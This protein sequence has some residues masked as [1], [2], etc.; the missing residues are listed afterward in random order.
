MN[1]EDCVLVG[2]INRKKDFRIL[3]EQGWYR[4]PVSQMAH[5][6]HDDYIAFFFSKAFGAQNGSIRYFAERTGVEQHT[7]LE[8]L[9]DE[10]KAKN[11]SQHYYKITVGQLQA[12]VPP[13]LNVDKHR[14]SFIYTTGDRFEAATTIRELF[15][16]GDDLL[17][18]V[19]DA[20]E[21]EKYQPKRR[22]QLEHGYPLQ[23]AQLR[24]L[25]EDGVVLASTNPDEGI[26]ITE[27]WRESL[28]LIKREVNA[29]GGLSTIITPL[30]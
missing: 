13:I 11:A 12:K 19:F 5:G 6:V 23:S 30:E 1:P 21:E 26:H 22:W 25:C 8:L 28:E 10:P 2:V 18:P 9:P 7:R 20:L 27:D 24:V 14:I 3:R 16:S 17:N 15:L 4:I 29:R